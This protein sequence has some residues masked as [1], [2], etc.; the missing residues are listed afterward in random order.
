MTAVEEQVKELSA[1]FSGRLLQPGDAAYDEARRVHNG[2]IDRRPALIARC[3][4]A[5]DAARAVV[6]ANEHGLEI[7]VA[8]ATTWQGR[9]HGR[10]TDDRLAEMKGIEVTRG[11]VRRERRAA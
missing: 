2:L 10:R 7:A 1:G 8:E 9:R 11:R 5:A 4:N 6:F 3:R